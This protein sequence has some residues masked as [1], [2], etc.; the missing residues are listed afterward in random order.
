MTLISLAERFIILI[1][2]NNYDMVTITAATTMIITTTAAAT[3]TA[4][5]TAAAKSRTDTRKGGESDVYLN[6][7]ECSPSLH[8]NKDG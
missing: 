1:Y 7:R 4:P 2:D 5:R 8:K 3:T 6:C